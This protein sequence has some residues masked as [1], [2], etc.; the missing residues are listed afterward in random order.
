MAYQ[1]I[2]VEFQ[3]NGELDGTTPAPRIS[4]DAS[5]PDYVRP[6]ERGIIVV[7]IQGNLGVIDPDLSG[8]RSSRGPRCIPWVW[9]DSPVP[10]D[11]FAQVATLDALPDQGLLIPFPQR[12]KTFTGGLPEFFTDSPIPVPMGSVLGILGYPATV[13]PKIV[14]FTV[15]G[16]S[17]IEEQAL[18]DQACCCL[19]TSCELQ[20]LPLI[21]GV[22]PFLVEAGPDQVL[23]ITGLNLGQIVGFEGTPPEVVFQIQSLNW[24]LIEQGGDGAVY[25]GV[26]NPQEE[27]STA[28]VNF[29][30][31]GAADG[32]YLLVGFDPDDP[33]CNT[34]S[35][36]FQLGGFP[37]VV[38]VG[39]PPELC[40]AVTS[41]EG[42]TT[43]GA[44]TT[45]NVIVVG[46]TGLTSVTV[47]NL[48]LVS[49]GL[50]QPNLV[51]T[52][53]QI[54]G[55]GDLEV[56]F[57]TG[58]LGGGFNLVVSGVNE[59]PTVEFFGAVFVQG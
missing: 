13:T 37:P 9:I 45:G 12:Q 14:R 47:A 11:L 10:G 33:V 58:V 44:G 50:P 38:G 53:A 2:T 59:C 41:V 52:D 56:T 15:L 26:V 46:G 40:P 5:D 22:D 36:V 29:N 55:D 35:G 32:N 30:L 3:V 43:P 21:Q 57:N 17:D 1:Q 18:I 23:T 39:D 25:H 28:V 49:N 20:N 31:T 24:V 19:Q 42:D 8:G 51:I 16:T 48:T 7:P 54:N 6:D 4:L 34:M 27:P